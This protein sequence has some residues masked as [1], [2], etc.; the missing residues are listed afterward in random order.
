MKKQYF[1]LPVILVLLLSSCSLRR[2]MY[3]PTLPQDP[4]LNKKGASDVRALFSGGRFDKPDSNYDVGFDVQAAYA[5]GRHL[6]F[7][8]AWTY[9][10]QVSNNN[11]KGPLRVPSLLQHYHSTADVG[12]GYFTALPHHPN[13]FFNLYGGYGF[14]FTRMSEHG[15]GNAGAYYLHYA[16]S[17]RK[18]YVQP[19]VHF[20]DPYRS[21]QTALSL[22]L[23]AV[24]YHDIQSDYTP[25]QESAYEMASLRNT[26]FLFAEP[27]ITVRLHGRRLP[28]LSMEIQLS[29]NLKINA[30]PLYYRFFYLSNGVS[31]D[32]S[33]LKEKGVRRNRRRT[34]Y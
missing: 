13:S 14:G 2:F 27:S 21:L 11:D 5:A 25:A 33:R 9:R 30:A 34:G 1:L 19:G 18:F 4:M 22:R 12:L 20:N 7:T 8:A 17:I 32:L 6:A 26:T 15:Q 29:G 24:R 16:A 31:V 10:D 28:W 23:S 3:A